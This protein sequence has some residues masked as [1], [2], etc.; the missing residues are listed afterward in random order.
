[1]TGLEAAILGFIQGS[2]EFL[3]VSSTGHLIIAQQWF[4][5][6]SDQTFVFDI[7]LHFATIFAVVIFFWKDLL[8]LRF[9]DLLLLVIASIPAVLI[10]L[11][12]HDQIEA[13]SSSLNTTGWEL[14]ITAGINFWIWHLLK[15][16]QVATKTE[17]DTKTAVIMGA[18]QAFSIIPAVSRSGSTVLGGLLRGLNRE[19]AF[20]FSFIMSIPVIVGAN[21]LELLKIMQ[22]S[23][24][25]PEVFPLIIGCI[26]AFIVG[27]FSLYVLKYMI[28]QAK[29]HWFGWYCLALG[30]ALIFWNLNR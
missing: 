12:F 7:F 25:T 6:H 2:T 18:F 24:P 4:G 28:T 29:F 20:K 26:V 19:T 13:L 3:P 17:V 1:M 21:G 16:P 8:Q 30:I 9:K 11:L 5:L 27:I 22:D 15:K 23:A 10:G 14:L